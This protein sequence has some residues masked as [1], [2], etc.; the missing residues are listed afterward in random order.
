MPLNLGNV[1]LE[2]HVERRQAAHLS[3]SHLIWRGSTG[4]GRNRSPGRTGREHSPSRCRQRVKRRVCGADKK[5]GMQHGARQA[6]SP[7]SGMGLRSAL[8]VLLCASLQS[9]ALHPVLGLLF[10]SAN[11]VLTLTLQSPKRPHMLH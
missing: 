7:V 5:A 10:L 9:K 2:A 4:D 8:M 11:A 1:G 6:G 3:H